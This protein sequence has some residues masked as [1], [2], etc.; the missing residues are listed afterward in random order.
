MRKMHNREKTEE[1][2][3]EEEVKYLNEVLLLSSHSFWDF[4]RN[5]R[6]YTGAPPDPN[7]QNKP[8]GPG[9][10]GG[11]VNRDSGYGVPT[12]T[13]KPGFPPGG[14]N[15][16][17]EVLKLDRDLG[18][19][20]KPQDMGVPGESKWYLWFLNMS[21]FFNMSKANWRNMGKEKS[22]WAYLKIF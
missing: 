20:F 19:S 5:Q 1:E 11:V 15:K 3:Y 18:I 22:I 21:F 12:G 13:G 9:Q 2:K 17:D 4:K 7:T 6:R 10:A 14:K 8:K 16:K